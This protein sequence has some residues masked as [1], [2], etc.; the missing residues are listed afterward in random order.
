MW[1]Q[2]GD[3]ALGLIENSKNTTYVSMRL[4]GLG[5]HVREKATKRSLICTLITRTVGASSHSVL[6]SNS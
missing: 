5:V 2:F 6:F 4:G 3:P 1:H